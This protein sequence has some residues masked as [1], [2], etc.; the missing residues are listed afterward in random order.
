MF[1]YSP[2]S[3]FWITNRIAQFAYLRYNE[4][5]AETRSVVDA[6]ETKKMNEVLAVDEAA[7][8]LHAQ[9]P[10][11]AKDFLTDYSVNTAQSLLNQWIKLDQYLMVKYIDGNTKGQNP[12]GTIIDN[13]YGV[14]IPGRI[15]SNGYNEVWKE[16]VGKSK[17]AET[18]KVK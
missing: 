6:W 12:D 10:Q 3:L 15:I 8:V 17:Q 16:A 14:G 5:G 7:K 9:N 4:I 1:E 13:G 18:L 2:T 11:L